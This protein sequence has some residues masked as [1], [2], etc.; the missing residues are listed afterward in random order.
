MVLTSALETL[1]VFLYLPAGHLSCCLAGTVARDT[2]TTLL[3]SDSSLS[4]HLLSDFMWFGPDV[5]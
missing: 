4:V 1:W 2:H 5:T 3:E